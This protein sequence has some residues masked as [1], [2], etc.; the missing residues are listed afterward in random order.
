[1]GKTSPN[2]WLVNEL[3]H[4][5]CNHTTAS[6]PTCPCF[7]DYTFVVGVKYRE[8]IFAL[9]ETWPGVQHARVRVHVRVCVCVC[10]PPFHHQI[11][12]LEFMGSGNLLSLYT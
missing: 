2:I 12:E 11:K 8:Y 6:A 3:S 10:M 7:S 5:G 1:M 4:S 9:I